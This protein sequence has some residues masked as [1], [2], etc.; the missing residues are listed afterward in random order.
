MELKK[1]IFKDYDGIEVETTM[2]LK[3]IQNKNALYY[4][5]NIDES[6]N[7]YLQSFIKTKDFEF[8]MPIEFVEKCKIVRTK[9]ES[10]LYLSDLGF[11]GLP[12]IVESKGKS[13][14]EFVKYCDGSTRMHTFD[15]HYPYEEPHCLILKTFN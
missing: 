10:I 9:D 14:I 1:T 12:P 5:V 7:P 3:P 4:F 11:S 15:T 2:I 6:G 8:T 13:A